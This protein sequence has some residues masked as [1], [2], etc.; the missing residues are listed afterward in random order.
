MQ[1]IGNEI[2]YTFRETL[3]YNSYDTIM[4]RSNSELART[5][6]N[7]PSRARCVTPYIRSLGKNGHVISR[8]QCNSIQG[9]HESNNNILMHLANPSF[10]PLSLVR[11]KKAIHKMTGPMVIIVSASQS[12][13]LKATTIPWTVLVGPGLM[14][15]HV[16]LHRICCEYFDRF[17]SQI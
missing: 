10:I 3:N 13:V 15:S 8:V 12:F 5:P 14:G 11:K 2:H 17:Q 9:A 1:Y 4:K 16:A 7:S 6:Y